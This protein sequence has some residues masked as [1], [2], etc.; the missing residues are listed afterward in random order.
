MGKASSPLSPSDLYKLIERV[1]PIVKDRVASYRGR[2]RFMDHEDLL[3][4]G[5]LAA[6]SS[7]KDYRQKPSGARP[8]TWVWLSVENRLRALAV[9]N[10]ELLLEENDLRKLRSNKP[11]RPTWEPSRLLACISAVSPQEQ[12]VLQS[13]AGKAQIGTQVA[14]GIGVTKQ[15]VYQIK[16]EAVRKIA[17]TVTDSLAGCSDMAPGKVRDNSWLLCCLD[18]LRSYSFATRPTKLRKHFGRAFLEEFARKVLVKGGSLYARTDDGLELVHSVDPGHAPEKLSFPLE[19]DSVYGYALKNRRP[20][21]IERV[22]E[23]HVRS[24]GWDGY[25]DDSA[26][27]C[28]ILGDGKEPIGV[29]CVYNKK[30]PPFTEEDI[31]LCSELSSFVEAN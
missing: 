23:N 21:L 30:K 31:E 7:L 1:I 25:E 18:G 12:T 11:L 20:L 3:Q 4:E 29:F 19:E 22:G 10:F 8:D 13:L 5:Y 17:E 15:R 9:K 16:R 27:V 28:P 2:I 14:P 6:I 26:L 24:S